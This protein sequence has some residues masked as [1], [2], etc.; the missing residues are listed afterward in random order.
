MLINKL[1]NLIFLPYSSYLKTSLFLVDIELLFT[2]L[3]FFHVMMPQC[4][5]HNTVELKVFVLIYIRVLIKMHMHKW[6][7]Y[8]RFISYL[9]VVLFFHQYYLSK[10]IFSML[11]RKLLPNTHTHT[12]NKCNASSVII[13]IISLLLPLTLYNFPENC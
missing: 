9:K 4:L 6:I 8:M 12:Q 1:F 7:I 10:V 3:L 2:I 13:V 5:T 11:F